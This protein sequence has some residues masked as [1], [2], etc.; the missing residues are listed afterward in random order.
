MQVRVDYERAIGHP[1]P[2]VHAAPMAV[3]PWYVTH[4]PFAAAVDTMRTNLRQFVAAYHQGQLYHATM[5][6]FWMKLLRH[7]LDVT[8]P[9]QAFADVVYAVLTRFGTMP[10]VSTHYSRDHLAHLALDS[11]WLLRSLAQ[12]VPASLV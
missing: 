6:L 8:E 1:S 5:T 3:A 7:V 2:Y 4:L 10:V 11:R 12:Q 9:D